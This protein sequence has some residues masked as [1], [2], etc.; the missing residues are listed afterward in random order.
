[1]RDFAIVEVEK[2]RRA[3]VRLQRGKVLRAKMR[4]GFLAGKDRK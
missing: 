3:I 1:M 2:V 4:V